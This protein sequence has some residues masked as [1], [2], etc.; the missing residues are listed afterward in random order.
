M[1]SHIQGKWRQQHLA[2]VFL[3]HV[4][5]QKC[6]YLGPGEKKKPQTTLLRELQ[7][8]PGKNTK[9]EDGSNVS[10]S[11]S[12]SAEDRICV[13]QI[14]ERA[15]VTKKEILLSFLFSTIRK[16]WALQM[17]LVSLRT[18]GREEGSMVKEGNF[19]EGKCTALLPITVL[20]QDWIHIIECNNRHTY[21]CIYTSLCVNIC[22]SDSCFYNLRLICLLYMVSCLRHFKSPGLTGFRMWFTQGLI[23]RDWDALAA[24]TLGCPFFLLLLS[25]AQ[26]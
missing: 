21:A 15:P 24:C 11:L 6:L 13:K 1:L 22:V 4:F 5:Y 23:H 20:Y 12:G 17:W 7:C 10:E 2:N 8:S 25:A 3:L 18:G 19:S 14:K 9:G 16:G 26:H